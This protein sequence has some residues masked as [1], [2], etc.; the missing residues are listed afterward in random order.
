MTPSPSSPDRKF[1]YCQVQLCCS[2]SVNILV[3]YKFQVEARKS[4]DFIET[5]EPIEHI[6]PLNK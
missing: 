4:T 1:L 2:D 5:V 3:S 6:E